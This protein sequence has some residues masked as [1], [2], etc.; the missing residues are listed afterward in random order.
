MGARDLTLGL[1][2]PG[3]A[4]RRYPERQRDVIPEHGAAGV[5][6]L[7]VAQ[8]RR[9]KLDV[10]ERLSRTGQRQLVLGRAI[11][12]VERGFRCAALGDS[13]QVLDGQ[14]R[15]QPALRRVQLRLAEAEKRRQPTD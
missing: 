11:G 13:A 12:V 4:R 10:L 6:G 7:D 3:E 15:L 1:H 5:E 8:Y 9:M 14:R 2:Q